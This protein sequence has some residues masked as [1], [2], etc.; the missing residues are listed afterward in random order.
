M[1]LVSSQSS[2]PAVERASPASAHERFTED[3]VG[4]PAGRYPSPS[5]STKQT[6]EPSQFW[7]ASSPAI[8]AA[9][10][11]TE[12]S[13]SLQSPVADDACASPASRQSVSV[14]STTPVPKR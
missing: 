3:R 10:G 6:S 13:A 2:V 12:A 5:A 9:P 14:D 4:S 7:S 8:S 11:E 1:A